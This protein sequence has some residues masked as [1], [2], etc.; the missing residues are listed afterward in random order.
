M[1]P[2][3]RIIQESFSPTRLAFMRLMKHHFALFGLFLVVGVSATVVFVP[4]FYGESPKLTRVWLGAN[5]PGFTHPDCSK[6]SIFNVGAVAET[7]NSLKG[8]KELI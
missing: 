2:D 1:K 3:K 5:P 6:N 8:I 7:S 4:M